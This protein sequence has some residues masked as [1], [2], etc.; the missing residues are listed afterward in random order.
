[1]IA[2]PRSNEKVDDKLIRPDYRDSFSEIKMGKGI[3]SKES[4]LVMSQHDNPVSI[5][6]INHAVSHI[7]VGE[8]VLREE[9]AEDITGKALHH[10]LKHN[11]KT[12]NVFPVA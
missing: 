7:P 4:S 12:E 8:V 9:T 1:M 11:K 5:T 3:F 10:S 6:G 2:R